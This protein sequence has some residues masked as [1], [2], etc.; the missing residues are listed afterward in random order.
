MAGPLDDETEPLVPGL[1]KHHGYGL[2]TTNSQPF[3]DSLEFFDGINGEAWYQAKQRPYLWFL[4]PTLHP[5]IPV[6]RVDLLVSNIFAHHS[7]HATVF[8]ETDQYPNNLDVVASRHVV[9]MGGTSVSHTYH[10]RTNAESGWGSLVTKYRSANTPEEVHSKPWIENT[11]FGYTS[12]EGLESEYE[13]EFDHKGNHFNI[14]K[15]IRPLTIG[16]MAA[17]WDVDMDLQE[18]VEGLCKD[19]GLDRVF[20]DIV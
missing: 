11:T 9:P 7:L 15:K 8:S 3:E 4:I 18:I 17:D 14:V 5:S 16:V 10:F 19:A 1:I 20:Q 2:L 12:V 13:I 6:E